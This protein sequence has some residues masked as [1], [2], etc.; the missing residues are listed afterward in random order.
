MLLMGYGLPGP[1]STTKEWST[2]LR[3]SQPSSG[4]GCGGENINLSEAKNIISAYIIMPRA[5]KARAPHRRRRRRRIPRPPRRRRVPLA[6]KQH[7]FVERAEVEHNLAINVEASAVGH[8]ETFSLSKMK[9]QSD[10]ASIFEF[11]R[12][13]KIVATFRYK[14]GTAGIAS[15]AGGANWNESNPLLYFKVDHN[16]I[17]ADTL[18]TMKESMKTKT[19][20][21]TNNKPEFSIV[22]KP[23]I[24]S[25]MYR[26]SVS[27]A[28]TPKWGQWIPTNDPSVPHY[29]LKAYA[30][31]YKSGSYDPGSLSVSYKYYVSFKNNE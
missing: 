14:G 26:S 21:I 2:A 19:K 24:Q 5:T 27:T 3:Y 1:C 30:I 8:F 22:L 25:E 10:Y 20:M 16:D 18:A 11:Y 23:A 4:N 6:L 17:T 9:Q 28:Y 31:G 7:A 29:G 12:I 15:V 13:D